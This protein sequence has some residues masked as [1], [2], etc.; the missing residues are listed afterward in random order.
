MADGGGPDRP[1]IPRDVL[2]RC[3]ATFRLLAH[4]DRLRIVEALEQGDRTVRD[5]AAAVGLPQPAT[6]QHLNQMKNRGILASHRHGKNVIYSLAD[7]SATVILGCVRDHAC[8][9]T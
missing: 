5:I 9:S 1:G 3:A 4:P 8:S 2:E 7:P 6:S